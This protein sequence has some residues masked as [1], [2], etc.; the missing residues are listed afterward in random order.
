MRVNGELFYAQLENLSSA[1]TPGVAGRV[2][3]RTDTSVAQYDTGAAV[4]TLLT[5]DY[6]PPL[7]NKQQNWLIN[8]NFDFW[9]RST[10]TA[11]VATDVYVAD[12]WKYLKAT[13][14]AAHTYSRST[15]VPTVTESGF[16]SSYSLLLDC[17]TADAAVAAGDLVTLVQTLEGY[18]WADLSGKTVTL[19]FWVKATKTGTSCVA[20]KSDSGFL[21]SYIAEYTIS[22]TATWEKKTI[23]LTL[24][25]SGGSYD[26]TNG[27]GFA[28][29]FTLMAGSTYQVAAGSWQSNNY[30]A[31][32]NQVNHCDDTANNFQI[33]QVMLQVGSDVQPFQRA[34][35]TPA[36]ELALCQRYYEKSYDVDAIPGTAAT[37]PGSSYVVMAR[38]N[39]GPWIKDHYKVSKRISPT[40]V[41]LYSPTTGASGV[42]RDASGAADVAAT[43]SLIGQSGHV[44]NAN[45]SDG[46]L[47]TWQWTAEAEL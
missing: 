4:K 7:Q 20:F 11:A 24:N 37:T 27:V 40:Q 31:T 42:I 1:P 2:W 25:P 43:A 41:T 44:M 13:T 33:A 22:T 39:N 12:R 46:S 34:G 47:A 14:A 6:T 8:G 28:V 30:Y 21:R 18:S 17:T 36:G 32:A 15:D 23:T 9:Q 29:A 38:T 5:T 10:S 3:Y 26:Y 19:T 16:Q 35:V 45:L